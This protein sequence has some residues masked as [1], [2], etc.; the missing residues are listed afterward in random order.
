MAGG[1]ELRIATAGAIVIY[2]NQFR[3]TI[4]PQ[5]VV[6][7]QYKDVTYTGHFRWYS[8]HVVA[9]FRTEMPAHPPV[10]CLQCIYQR[11][12]VFTR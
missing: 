4:D 6:H 8:G 7:E 2:E 3:Y 9:H 11:I 12:C 1:L 5:G 10:T